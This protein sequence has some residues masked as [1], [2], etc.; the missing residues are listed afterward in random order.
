[1]PATT[2]EDTM[3]RGDRRLEAAAI[4]E[5]VARRVP[6]SSLLA[7]VLA[8][9]SELLGD[10]EARK[11]ADIELFELLRDELDDPQRVL[12]LAARVL[13]EATS[14]D[15][16]ALGAWLERIRSVKTPEKLLPLKARVLAGALG[17]QDID[18]PELFTLARDAGLA[19]TEAGNF[20]AA[21][22]VYEKALMPMASR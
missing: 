14:R 19:L 5:G 18:G 1:M 6:Q 22:A 17:D 16:G 13:K 4:L 7:D 8:V 11:A 2:L 9:Q 21:S 3:A 12:A 20:D 15:R 10:P